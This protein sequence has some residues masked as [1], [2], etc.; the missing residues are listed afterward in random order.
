M[1]FLDFLFG[2][3]KGTSFAMIDLGGASI[4][5]LPA[6]LVSG[7][8]HVF[9]NAV[10]EHPVESGTDVTDHIRPLPLKLTITG[11]FSDTPISVVDAIS[12]LSDGEPHTI[13]A[14]QFFEELR[15]K[16]YLCNISNRFK[17]YN[18]M[19]VTSVVFN[20]GSNSGK[21]VQMQ[22]NFKEVRT[23]ES[24]LL[25]GGVGGLGAAAALGKLATKSP[26]AAVG[27][28]AGS[29]LSK[30]TGLGG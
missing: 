26:A 30:I 16:R 28:A 14:L 6:D 19:A 24:A 8:S 4:K 12:R 25:A 27:G 1:A 7:E 18:N 3:A 29:V 20:R 13:R 22:V 5:E 2:G 21:S 10:T 17:S 23:V 9:E 11:V 15:D